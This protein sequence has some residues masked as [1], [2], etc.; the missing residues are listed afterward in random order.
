MRR[1]AGQ[2]QIG[3]RGVRL[4]NLDHLR[5]EEPVRAP[6]IYDVA[7][8]AGVSHQTVSRYLSGFEGIRPETK[9]RVEAALKELDY[10]PNSAAR[11]LRLN[12]VNRIAALADALELTGPLRIVNGA[13]TEAQRRG[14]VLDIIAM[15]GSDP[16]SVDDAITLATDHQVSGILATAQTEVVLNRLNRR[17]L[18]V[19]LVIGV[20]VTLGKGGPPINEL[21]G[22]VAAEHLWS[23]GHR[24][25]GYLSGPAA[26][27]AARSRRRGFE[28]RLTELGGSVAWVR[29]GDWSPSSG[30]AVWTTLSPPDRAVSAVAAAND[31]MA[32][33]LIYALA[34]AGL[35]VPDDISVVGTDDL[36]ESGFLLPPLSTI[37]MDFE[38]EGALLMDQLLNLIEGPA[39][40]APPPSLDP[41]R[42]IVRGST[43]PFAT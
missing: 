20:Q 11:A 31:S 38:G 5:Y 16:E 25:I 36:P 23:L 41:P 10:R 4:A 27:L 42:L 13:T 33:G 15:D 12:R 7:R 19:P 3:S 40:S 24:R 1:H 14:Y 6:T 32:V 2:R 17:R 39:T 35:R 9:S 22:L 18:N 26:W 21:A 8:R 28:D 43:R 30:H 37:A 34:E 29:E